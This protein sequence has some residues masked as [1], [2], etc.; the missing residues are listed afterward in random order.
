MNSLLEG[1]VELVLSKISNSTNL[2]INLT[3]TLECK[4][5]V[6]E[7]VMKVRNGELRVQWLTTEQHEF[8][9]HRSTYMQISFINSVL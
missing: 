1:T 3:L 6:I 9:L 8:E 7:M 2:M 4:D 5:D